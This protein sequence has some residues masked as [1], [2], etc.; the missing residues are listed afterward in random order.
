MLGNTFLRKR[1]ITNWYY[2]IELAK[3]LQEQKCKLDESDYEHI[4]NFLKF[5]NNFLNNDE[6]QLSDF[7]KEIKIMR[8][9]IWKI[10]QGITKYS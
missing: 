6:V 5:A 7:K 1:N 9:L 10:K 8:K 2:G 3:I 4:S